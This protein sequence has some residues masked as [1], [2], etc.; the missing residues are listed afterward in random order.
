MKQLGLALHNYHDTFMRFPPG[1][2]THRSNEPGTNC[3]MGGSAPADARAPWTVLVLPYME[4]AAL[5]N[6][7]D[8]SAPFQGMFPNDT[9]TSPNQP[10]QW[11]PNQHYQCPSDPNNSKMLPNSNYYGVQGGGATFTHE[12]EGNGTYIPS[13]RCCKSSSGPQRMLY[14]NG[15]FFNNSRTEMRDLIDGSTNTFMLG[16][17]RYHHL[18]REPGTGGMSWASGFRT[19]GNSS[20]PGPV[21]AAVL[22][23]NGADKNASLV[24]TADER[25]VM[26]GSYHTGG[27]HFFMADASVHFI[28]EN[29]DIGIYRSL[30]II[31][32]GLPA[33]GFQP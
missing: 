17:T 31:N 11:E 14:Y 3:I 32:D 4:E 30:G 7:F 28:S 33:G 15:M 26:F 12:G 27:C 19:N 8:L 16:E 18:N 9:P 13:C 6:Q 10:L 1:G 23:I 20:L 21:A 24:H 5:Y 25:T 22:P 2:V 29:I